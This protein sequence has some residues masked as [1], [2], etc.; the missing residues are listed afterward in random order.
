VLIVGNK[1][2][3]ISV[4]CEQSVTVPKLHNLR[5]DVLKLNIQNAIK[6]FWRNK[7]RARSFS[8]ADT[9]SITKYF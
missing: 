5:S 9:E 8:G 1:C 4:T 2:S 7:K 3:I 6:V